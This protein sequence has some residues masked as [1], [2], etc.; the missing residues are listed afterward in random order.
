M[1]EEMKRMTLMLTGI[2]LLFGVSAPARAGERIKIAMGYI[3]NVQ[4]AP[5]YI[6]A[7]MGYFQEERLDVTFDYGMAA[8]IMSLVASGKV[9]FGVSDGDQL[10]IAR[11]HGIPVR[12][13]YTMYVKYPVA[14]ASFK[15]RGIE[16]IPSL[17][18]R[19]VGTP[20]PYGANYTGL[21]I[22]LNG[23]GLTLK[24][25][26]LEFIGYTQVESLIAGKVDAAV[27]FINNEPIVL[28]NMGRE[29]NLIPAYT[30]TPM[31]SAAIIT[32]ERYIEKKPDLVRRFVRSVVR[33]SRYALDHKDEA[34]EL[35]KD[36]IPT[37]TK[38]N[39]EINDKVLR[40]SMELWVDKDIERYG[41][42]STTLEDWEQSIEI[43]YTLGMIKK[44]ISPQECFTNEF[45]RSSEAVTKE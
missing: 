4:F 36:Y 44:K 31:V 43:M 8:D 12:V 42:G 10:I 26:G 18:G 32:S 27:V 30:A 39:R 16:D 15:E 23:A 7:E 37:L 3:P 19:K 41:L 9:D 20:G 45:A 14:I 6:A 33:G 17:K 25:I 21:Q 13:V 40:A 1:E 22:L 2:M 34:L 11:D 38:E 28:E 5:Y 29:L 35:M 24:D